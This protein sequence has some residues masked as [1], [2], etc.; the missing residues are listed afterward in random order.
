MSDDG[1]AARRQGT[2][3]RGRRRASTASSSD[4]AAASREGGADSSHPEDLLN[5]D[6]TLKE[7]QSEDSGGYLELES[8]TEPC[9]PYVF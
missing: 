9:D 4:G 8:G 5:E 3:A 7:P 2:A 6:G 1:T